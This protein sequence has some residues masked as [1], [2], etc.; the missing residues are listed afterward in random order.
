MVAVTMSSPV[1]N[2]RTGINSATL[3]PIITDIQSGLD[4]EKYQNEHATY[5]FAT[6]VRDGISGQEQER[7]ETRNG[8]HVTGFYK[9]SDEAFMHYVS[10]VADEN[11]FRIVKNEHVP[12]VQAKEN[13]LSDIATVDQEAF[14]K[15]THYSIQRVPVENTNTFVERFDTDYKGAPIFDMEEAEN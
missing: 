7:Q 8:L 4:L 1:E 12:L 6:A 5:K 10:Y 9:Y 13:W 11:G 15:R 14:G 3:K 2:R